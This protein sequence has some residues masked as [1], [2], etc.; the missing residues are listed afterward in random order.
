MRILIF[1]LSFLLLATQAY[2]S[3][4]DIIVEKARERTKLDIRYDPAYVV[5]SYPGGDV[6]AD[7]G[8]CTDVIIRTFRTAF[9][10]D[11]Q[12]AVH[13]DMRANFSAYPKI[14]GLKRADKNIDHRRVPNLERFLTRQGASLP[15][16]KKAEDYLPG[17]IVT[18][19]LGGRLPHMG[20]VSDRKSE[21]GTPLIIH[22]VGQGPVE[23]DLLFNTDINGHFRF[24]PEGVTLNADETED[25][26]AQAEE[27][28]LL[29]NG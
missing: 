25:E 19:R 11:F 9:G 14:W 22:N 1:I 27:P 10:F 16:T 23:D 29:E 4:A 6:P 18:W 8:V 2:A 3:P 5:L 12:K 7:T 15:I 21:W 13:E 26:E 24:I 28:V 17:D 20:I